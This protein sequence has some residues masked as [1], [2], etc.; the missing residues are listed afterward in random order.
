MAIDNNEILRM[1]KSPELRN[2][3]FDALVHAFTQ[4]LYWHIRRMVVVHDDAA[5][6]LQETW[7]KVFD[8]I[9][10]FRGSGAELTAWLYRIATNN[11]L[12]MLRHKYRR[13]LMF[14]DDP[15]S[16]LLERFAESEGE[17]S[18]SIES[19]FQKALLSLPTKQRTVFNLRYYD[20]LSYAEISRITGISEASL[21]T[22]YHYAQKRI[23][24]L[25]IL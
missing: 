4:R 23:K 17:S 1:L 9:G 25:M 11:C 21:K 10:S 14:F 2:E 24:E 3:G 20:E 13:P 18:E 7:I 8:G 15:G 16:R 6:L 22:N 19:K 12:S 5:D